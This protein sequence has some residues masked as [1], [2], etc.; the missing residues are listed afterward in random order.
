MKIS[1]PDVPVAEDDRFVAESLARSIDQGVHLRRRQRKVVFVMRS[2]A[3]ER[4][5]AALT[6][7]PNVFAFGGARGHQPRLCE[8]VASQAREEPRE[9]LV[10][11][12]FRVGAA[13]RRLHKKEEGSFCRRQRILEMLEMLN[14][15]GYGLAVDKLE[16]VER[17]RELAPRAQEH[18]DAVREARAADVGEV[19]A[20][21]ERRHEQGHLCDDAERAFGA[22]KDLLQ[23]VS[24]IVLS[25]RAQEVEHSSIREHHLQTEDRTVQRS[26]SDQVYASRICAHVPANLARPLC[27]ELVRHLQSVLVQLLVEDAKHASSLAHHRSRRGI[28]FDDALHALRR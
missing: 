6:D 5:W 19:V 27:A 22:D 9:T 16:R 21:R 15:E 28:H 13:T 8:I 2:R 18:L 24:G 1:V 3:L 25:E 20:R 26:V 10:L 4:L 23:V 17:A 14:G 11:V 7:A 12:F